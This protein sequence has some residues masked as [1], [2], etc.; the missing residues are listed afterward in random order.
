M[1]STTPTKICFILEIFVL[2]N[3]L[4][5]FFLRMIMIVIPA[6]SCRCNVYAVSLLGYSGY[7]CD[8]WL[9]QLMCKSHWLL[10]V[11]YPVLI[12]QIHKI[13]PLTLLKDY[14]FI[15]FIRRYP[16]ILLHYHRWAC[17]LYIYIYIYIY[18]SAQYEFSFLEDVHDLNGFNQFS[19]LWQNLIFMIFYLLTVSW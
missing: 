15:K 19:P 17:N 16:A 11:Q 12:G 9:R 6:A 8:R 3:E 10:I 14:L 13:D 7:P 4:F 5:S 1:I 2:V 18:I